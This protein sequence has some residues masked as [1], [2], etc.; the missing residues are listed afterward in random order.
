MAHLPASRALSRFRVLDLTRVRAGPA[1]T[2][3]LAD[4][5]A[6]VIRV[7]PPASVEADGTL[8]ARR[9]TAD[10]A[11][12]NRNKRSL[13][14]NL[15][16]PDGVALFKRLAAK[17]DIVVENFRPAVKERL[18]IDYPT[19]AELNP[20]LVYASVS[21]FGQDGPYRDRVAFDQIVQ[22]MGG[23]MS[24]TGLPG[25]GPVR[26]G[27]P[28]ADLSAGLLCAFAILVALIERETSGRG[29][30]VTTSL[31]EAQVFM[32][33]F[34]A[35]RWLVDG[36]VAGQ[37]GNNHPTSM[38]TGLYA[39]CDGQINLA[40][41]GDG[42]W[43]RFCAAVGAD[44]LLANPDYATEVDRGRNRV[45]LNAELARILAT[46]DSRH[47]IELLAAHGV[48]CGEVNTIDRVF[49]DPQVRL[50]GIATE[51]EGAADG[52]VTLVGQPVKLARTPSRL[53]R[54]APA[55]GEH[56]DEVLAAAGLAR[57]EIADL[58]RRGI[59]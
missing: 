19:L 31:L 38:P 39:T 9:A 7:E 22:G 29:Q 13:T 6:D 33:D 42:G 41:A 47:W 44:D 46:A 28:I 52:A 10:F 12:L 25:Q 56:T 36:E 35:A 51:V 1:A 59:V 54:P 48:A 45:A 21:G 57:E 4:W 17:A 55:R 16:Q 40:C 3:Q 43:R 50:C 2:R 14:L 5:G 24:I 11:N 18:G 32:L 8:G 23:L 30:W 26:V 27:I 37:A 20:R 53:R 49:A 58:R 15:K 34:Q